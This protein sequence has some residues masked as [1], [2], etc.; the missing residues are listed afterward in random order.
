MTGDKSYSSSYYNVSDEYEKDSYEPKNKLPD[1]FVEKYNM[2][3]YP[4]LQTDKLISKFSDSTLFFIFYY[5]PSTKS[6]ILAAD[7]LIKRKW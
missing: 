6:Q 4:A 1:G 3:K 2:P 7:E 5:Q